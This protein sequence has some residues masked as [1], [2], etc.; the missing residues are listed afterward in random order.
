VPHYEDWRARIEN[1]GGILWQYNHA[2]TEHEALDGKTPVQAWQLMAVL[3]APIDPAAVRWIA[4]DAY[5]VLIRDDGVQVLDATYQHEA[6]DG[7]TGTYVV[8]LVDERKH[9]AEIFTDEGEWLCTAVNQAE[10]D[11]DRRLAIVGRRA[12]S[13]SRAAKEVRQSLEAAERRL[14]VTSDRPTP[15]EPIDALL[16]RIRRQGQSGFN[17]PI[18][19]R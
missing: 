16:E 11:D 12:A 14:P 17:Q 4:R 19:E 9:D 15:P 8:A 18:D 7:R 10:Q 6:F 5:R 2:Y 13:R 1:D 3:P